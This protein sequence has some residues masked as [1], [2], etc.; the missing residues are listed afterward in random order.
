MDTNRV[1]ATAVAANNEDSKKGENQHPSTLQRW[2]RLCFS[3]ERLDVNVLQSH[4][5]TNRHL[6]GKPITISKKMEI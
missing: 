6:Y 5:K 4:P 3:L 2:L 1:G